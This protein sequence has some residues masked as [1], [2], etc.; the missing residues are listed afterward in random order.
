M[1]STFEDELQD[2]IGKHR[3]K[4]ATLGDIISSLEIL[5]MALEEEEGDT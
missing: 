4:G 5:K 1:D 3:E 2:L